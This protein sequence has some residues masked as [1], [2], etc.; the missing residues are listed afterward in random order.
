M[1]LSIVIYGFLLV[2]MSSLAHK[3]DIKNKKDIY[4]FG[5]SLIYAI[6]FGLR[7]GVGRDH[8]S[9]LNN[10]LAYL[11][12]TP[13]DN[14]E[15]GFAFLQE[16]FSGLNLH[17]IVFFG[18]IS[19]VEIFIFYSVLK[20]N[21]KYPLLLPFTILYI[22]SAAW[23]PFSSGLRQALAF[24]FFMLALNYTNVKG[25]LKYFI[26]VFIAFSLHKSA[27]VL[28][29]FYPIFLIKKEWFR[30]PII[31][32]LLY[33]VAVVCMV[34]H[35][36]ESLLFS[37]DTQF[38]A[39]AT[40]LNYDNYLEG[41]L[42]ELIY[43]KDDGIG[44]GQLIYISLYAIFI[45]Y[46]GKVK[47]YFNDDYLSKSYDLFFIG[48]LMKSLFNG[49][50]L[51]SRFTWYFEYFY[52]I[53]GAYILVYLYKYYKR[54]FYCALLLVSLIFAAILYRG[55]ENSSYYYFYWEL[56]RYKTEHVGK[57]VKFL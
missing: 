41:D 21:R 40:F 22:L 56:D 32:L 47:R 57:D 15:F 28:V 55:D 2:I 43:Q 29:I 17:P 6:V 44:L 10:Y 13:V 31:E 25:L 12:G 1:L 53:V 50:N 51:F 36:F 27:A 52:L 11:K 46:S 39:A 4:I 45:A 8:P 9:Y 18:F 34:S 54:W 48:S 7:F 16:L 49:S 42:A 24:C 3:A 38:A 30:R 35:V 20:N 14:D 26:L 23:L 33:G 19:F 37:L 5:A